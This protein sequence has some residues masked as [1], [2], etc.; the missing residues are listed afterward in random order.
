MHEPPGTKGRGYLYP[1]GLPLV[2]ISL[3]YWTIMEYRG[4]TITVPAVGIGVGNV[5]VTVGG[6]DAEW[7]S[8]PVYVSG[9]EWS[10]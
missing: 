10:A 6:D 7:K 1:L 3:A 9:S 2:K 5:F 8:R 4:W